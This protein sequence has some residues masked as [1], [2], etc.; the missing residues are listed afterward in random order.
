MR[1]RSL[2]ILVVVAFSIGWSCRKD[3]KIVVAE[4]TPYEIEYPSL[5]VST[6]GPM[7]IPEDNPMT[8]EGV[9]L[10]KKLFYEERISGSGAIS[11][12]TCH[13]Q[14]FAFST[15]QNGLANFDGGVPRNVMPLFNLGWASQ[16]PWDG[17]KSSLEAKIEESILVTVEGDPEIIIPRLEEDPFYSAEFE[18]VF[19]DDEITVERMAKAM[20]QF[21]RTLISGDTPFDR[22]M[23]T[24]PGTSGLSPM[25]ELRMYQGYSIFRDPAKGDCQ[26]CHGDENNGL[27]TNNQ[28]LN[29]GMDESFSDLGYGYVTGSPIHEGLF[30]APSIRNLA[31]TAPYM[32]DGRFETIEEVVDHYSQKVVWSPTISGG[33]EF[34]SNGGVNLTPDERELLVFFLECL[35]DTSFTT[36]SAYME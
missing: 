5:I 11:C 26:H 23:T 36:N 32:H 16:F 14:E 28:M 27:F 24:G 15:P 13:L 2:V 12:N 3:P 18:V 8:E 7:I 35:S 19:G 17:R 6:V 29:N 25:D 22:Y 31:F 9:A 34:V 20:S 30:K 4:T 21:F 33:M 1:K 10:G